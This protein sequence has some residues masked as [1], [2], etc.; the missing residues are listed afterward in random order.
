MLLNGTQTYSSSHKTVP[1]CSAQNP[2]LQETELGKRLSGLLEG[3]DTPY[4]IP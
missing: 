3:K 2:Q 4:G 1:T